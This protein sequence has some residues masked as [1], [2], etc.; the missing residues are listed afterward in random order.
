MDTVMKVPLP[1]DLYFAACFL[2]KEGGNEAE[3]I[4]RLDLAN[5]Q[6]HVI[7]NAYGDVWSSHIPAIKALWPDLTDKEL[8]TALVGPRWQYPEPQPSLP[9]AAAGIRDVMVK[10]PCIGPLAGVLRPHTYICDDPV[11]WLLYYS[12]NGKQVFFDGSP[13]VD[14]D[15]KAL[16]LDA[17]AFRPLGG[18]YFTDS[19]VIL[20]QGQKDTGSAKRFWWP[21]TGAN[22]ASFA[23]LNLRYAKDAERAWYITGKEIR[24]KSPALFEV[25]P[26]LRLNYRD[27]TQE[28]MVEESRV[29]RDGKRVYSYGAIIRAADPRSFRALGH[30]Y[31]TDDHKVWR[32]DGKTVIEGADAAS[33]RVPGP[34]DPPIGPSAGSHCATDRNQPYARGKPVPVEEAFEGW[35]AFFSNR[36]DAAQ[37]WWGRFAEEQDTSSK[38]PTTDG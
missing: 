4:A 29:A 19:H 23:A 17:T 13:L 37:W 1:F 27:K 34:L 36:P 16:D 33:I 22:P 2:L 18:R 7:R 14:R 25:V 8:Y 3:I 30:D 35:R 9:D 10:Q 12:H 21:L 20:G 26:D 32:N 28:P 11:A 6:W 15:G 38:A 24:T 31:W 5:D